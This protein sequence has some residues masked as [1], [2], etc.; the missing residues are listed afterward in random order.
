MGSAH[1]IVEAGKSEIGRAD[2]QEEIPGGVNAGVLRQR[3]FE[4]ESLLLGTSSFK[5]FNWLSSTVL[6]H[7]I[8]TLKFTVLN[9]NHI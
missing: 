7:M 1:A 5:A 4:A 3:R 8:C 2:Q 9:P 6:Q